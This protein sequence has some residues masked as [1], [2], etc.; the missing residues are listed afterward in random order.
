MPAPSHLLMQML[1]P[2]YQLSALDRPQVIADQTIEL[3][4]FFSRASRR[5]ST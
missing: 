3:S 4:I 5:R 2:A 1:A